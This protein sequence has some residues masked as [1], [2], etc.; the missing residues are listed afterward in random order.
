MEGMND[1]GEIQSPLQDLLTK[2]V[3]GKKLMDKVGLNNPFMPGANVI[4]HPGAHKKGLWGDLE[5]L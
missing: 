5:A 1:E 4:Y 3:K 2:M